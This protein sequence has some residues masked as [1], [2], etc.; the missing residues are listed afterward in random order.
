MT[1]VDQDARDQA[2]DISQSICVTAP[3]GS[4]KTELLTQ[5]LLKLLAVVEKPEQVLAITFTRKAAA[6]MR[7]RVVDALILGGQQDAPAESHK[8]LT[9]HLAQA[10]LVNSNHHNWE[11]AKNPARIRVQTI[12]SLCQSITREQPIV[13]QFG[14]SPKAVDNA[15]HLYDAAVDNLLAN[16][17][18]QSDLSDD[19]AGALLHV[20]NNVERLKGLLT[21][22][23][24]KR[25]QWL[26]Y[27][28]SFSDDDLAKQQLSADLHKWIEEEIHNGAE[29]LFDYESDLCQL[30]DY[31]AGHLAAND[32]TKSHAIAS[33]GGI[34]ELP[35]PAAEEL[36]KWQA[37][38]DF[39]LT[40]GGTF[41]KTVNKKNGFPAPGDAK[42]K[43]EK[44]LYTL[45]KKQCIEL[46]GAV[47]NSEGLEQALTI[48][49]QLPAQAYGE[50][51]WALLGP[52]TRLLN[53]GVGH[54][55]L[56]F[57]QTGQCDH[58]EI[59]SAAL[60]SLGDDLAPT[61]TRL[62]WD[63][64]LRHILVDEFQDT[65][66]M[67]FGLVRKLTNNWIEE[68]EL[69]PENPR[70][71]FVVGDGMQSIYGFRAAKV[72]LFLQAKEQGIGDLPL[73][74]VQLEQNFR[75]TQAVVEWN[76]TVFD[77]AFPRYTDISRGA[78]PFYP[79]VAAQDSGN[80]SEVTVTICAN[81]TGR[82]TEAQTVV[83]EI[84]YAQQVDPGGSIAV[85]VRGRNHLADIIPA[86]KNADIAWQATDID[87]LA[88]TEVI[89]DLLSLTKALL[90]P[91]DKL[92][93]L[94]LLRA[95]FCGL[96]LPD[97]HQLTDYATH[98]FASTLLAAS[99]E[100]I[101][102]IGLTADGAQ[103]FQRVIGVLKQSWQ[104]RGRKP[105]R[106]WIES[107]WHDI[108]GLAV[109][110]SSEHYQNALQY[111]DLL[112]S[113]DSDTDGFSLTRLNTKLKSLYAKSI[114]SAD[115]AVQ[116]M[117]IHKSKGLEFDTVILPAIDRQSASD[118]KTLLFWN[119]HLYSDG[120]TGLVL[121]PLDA[122]GDESPLYKFLAA[123][124][125]R[126]VSLEYTRLLYVAATRAKKRLHLIANGV[127]S[128]DGVVKAPTSNSLLAKIWPSVK[129]QLSIVVAT[130]P[131]AV[132][133]KQTP[134]I[135]TLKRLPPA[136]ALTATVDT[137]VATSTDAD[138]LAT[139]EEDET[140]ASNIA[141]ITGIVI[142]EILQAIAS[143][144]LAMWNDAKIASLQAPWRMRLINS[145]IGQAELDDAL[146][147]TTKA[148]SNSL[149]D[150][151]G[152]WLLDS[153]RSDSVCEWPLTFNSSNILYHYVIDR[154][155]VADGERWII[156]YKSA[157]P[158][159]GQSQ[160][161]FIK[162]QVAQYSEQLARYTQ[163]CQALDGLPVRTALYFPSI[164]CLH[165]LPPSLF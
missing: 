158:T 66:L 6:E 123:E 52:L 118:S 117:T 152:R 125:K 59:T 8:V 1:A 100:K 114:Q 107:A 41:R 92:A 93:W 24:A 132:G 128:D 149:N 130:E 111:F 144:D 77:Q 31:A 47:S 154:S 129:D 73:L 29:L 156:D 68:N 164:P 86:L 61:T 25:D 64:T 136:F 126:A 105:L 55:K 115:N 138:A 120:D 145:G 69:D 71:L 22:L 15:A 124:Q 81:D 23:L 53:H 85:L 121:C 127:V 76:N 40:A 99:D 45:R 109:L 110:A 21:G 46:I 57:A 34:T 82:L 7:E 80:N 62:R 162:Q 11:L 155:F 102:S 70:T 63:H 91:A 98:S 16:L 43:E 137:T 108:G 67:Q 87:P 65:A 35:E 135:N 103:I 72:G 141:I 147:A 33:L 17:E 36:V 143:T 165:E 50:D 5:R 106:Q 39:L 134:S 160:H 148:I 14:S 131:A 116:I 97:L 159:K 163:A 4:G 122:T 51:Q 94:A 88:K 12:D 150:E 151:Q 9:W 112:E 3:A 157:Q 146:A 113:L 37:V 19:I 26:S 20:D 38:V 44:A 89:V 54:L 133:D 49:S 96:T 28:V 79:A 119:E 30:I 13:S 58:L 139:Q 60:L 56:V 140:A 161:E 2:L 75:S 153:A 83:K 101:N 10:A 18:S 142:H 74:D 78:V 90:N 48:L 95:P 32:A 84:H 27:T 42:D 104:L